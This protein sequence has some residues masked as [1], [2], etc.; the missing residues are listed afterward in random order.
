VKR[1]AWVLENILGTPPPPPPPNVP[2]LVANKGAEPVTLRQ[3]LEQHREDKACAACHAKIDPLGFAFENYD[4]VGAFREKDGET[5]IDAS[6]TLPDGST[7]NGVVE[8][9]AKLLQDKDTFT[10]FLAERMLTYALG[11]G[12]EY[13]D[14]RAIDQ[15]V[16]D[17]AK[18]DYKFSRLV[19]AIV[20]S[21]PFR[22]RR[23][24]DEDK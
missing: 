15:I 1:G 7:I 23:G 16:S 9:R 5:D 24:K 18:D 4:A 21:D 12:V 17:V 22:L 20:N 3:R 10:R 13:Y 2:E 11:R 8:L 6:G 14:R 19:T